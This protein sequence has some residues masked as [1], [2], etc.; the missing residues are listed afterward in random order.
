MRKVATI[1][2]ILEHVDMGSHRVKAILVNSLLFTAETWSGVREADLVRLEQVDQA[3]MN[4]LVS[5]H[6]KCPREFAYLETG[7]LKLSHILTIN[8]MMYHHHLIH[9]NQSETIRKIYEKQKIDK[10]NGY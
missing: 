5:G 2:G 9:T 4:S 1:N 7:T 8:R 3:L 10:T 6:S